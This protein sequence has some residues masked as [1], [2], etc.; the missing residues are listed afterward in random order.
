[1]IDLKTGSVIRLRRTTGEP[2]DLFVGGALIGRAE[3][4]V[5]GSS[6]KVQVTEVGDVE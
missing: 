2:L 3:V 5:R 4:L 6:R 1:L